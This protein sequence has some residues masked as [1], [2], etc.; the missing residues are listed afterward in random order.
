MSQI[1]DHAY[2][3]SVEDKDSSAE[4][5]AFVDR[6][7]PVEAS[8][9]EDPLSRRTFLK[10]MGASIAL[11]GAS[12][13]TMNIRKPVQK[14]R[15]YAKGPEQ[16]VPG[17]P[18]YYATA[19]AVGLDVAGLLVQ[20][21]EGRP[22]KVEGNPQHSMSLGAANAWHQASVLNL[23]D[24]DRLKMPL[25][26]NEVATLAQFKKWII[27]TSDT[28]RQSK[29]RGV[30]ILSEENVSPTYQRVLSSL[31]TEFPEIAFYRYDSV[32]QDAIVEGMSLVMGRPAV[33]LYD[34]ALAN[35][36]LSFDADFLGMDLGNLKY[37]KGFATRR[38]PENKASMN[39]LYMAESHYSVTGGKA[40][41]RFRLSPQAIEGLVIEVVS[42]IL[43]KSGAY[44]DVVS[45]LGR[46]SGIRQSGLASVTVDAIVADLISEG[47]YSLLVAGARMPAWVHGLIALANQTLGAVGTTVGY[48]TPN[49]LWSLTGANLS[50]IRDLSASIRQGNV[51]TL[52]IMG[53]NPVYDTP[54]DVDFVAAMAKVPT[55]IHLSGHANETSVLATWQ[56]PRSHTLESWGDFQAQDGSVSVGQPLIQPLYGSLS[57][58]AFLALLGGRDMGDFEL[59]RQQHKS[60]SDAAWKKSLHEGV[61]SGPAAVLSVKPSVSALVDVLGAI[62][63]L[64]PV[65][66][67]V[68]FRPDFKVYDGRFANNGWLQE[69]PDPVT[70]LTWDNAAFV[71][72]TTARKLG[73]D[74]RAGGIDGPIQGVNDRETLP[75]VMLAKLTVN[76]QEMTTAVMV[77]PGHADDTVTLLFGYG[78][79]LAG[80]VG[81]NT[82]FNVYPVFSGGYV[83]AGATLEKLPG[84][85]KIAVT[86]DHWG[87]EGRP[88]YR[89][90]SVTEY[91]E[92]PEFAKEMV[93]HPPLLSPWKEKAYDTGYQWGMAIDLSKC[94]GCNACLVACQS[95]NNIPIVG[96]DQVAN[97]REMHWIR[98]DR[99]YEGT[100]ED[101]VMVQQPVTCLQCENAPC[102]QVC[103]VAAT[104]HTADGLND[105]TYNRCI[106]TKYCSN[107]CPVKVRRFNFLDY[108]QRNPQAVAKDRVHLF[109][110]LK[111]PDKT[112]QKQF[113][114]NVTVRMRGV[115]EKCTYCIQRISTSRITAK[116][117][118]RPI[119]DGEIQT[120]CMQTCP[121]DAITFGNI[122]DPESRVSKVKAQHRDYH[123]LAELNLKPRTSYLAAIRNPNPK[124]ETVERVS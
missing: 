117:E 76:G 97:G 63:D 88:L 79:P 62:R 56:I 7:F 4:V 111:E 53:G 27:E 118:G 99:Y 96:K 64:G 116:N 36:V 45:A 104:T 44:A 110:Y 85:Y 98:L 102:E 29:G 114:P 26:Q 108:H 11:A 52:V 21:H 3:K 17:H 122:L 46:F 112:I 32:N 61:L 35:R 60:L 55:T 80:R 68:S 90:G 9:L 93:E 67:Q 31:K 83:Q 22:T 6:E 69:L 89:E 25:F 78:R 2:W 24:P 5:Q 13:C 30:A 12:G 106:G 123:M 57:D 105:M 74:P 8:I 81:K 65:G 75:N 86:Q 71:S 82:G 109:D 33:P 48:Y 70:K 66:L 91:R 49:G 72:R 119:R 113:N 37:A 34:F 28:W 107:N 120:A 15:P 18:V 54:V 39:R 50:S 94:T 100:E 20:S 10:I 14:I 124:L 84:T 51:S 59:V 40:D 38:D 95:E 121:S 103:P 58:A 43:A 87:M 73:L 115:M 19:M 77:Q 23:Y 47:K 41:H 101:A 42:R 16:L 92:H 1:K